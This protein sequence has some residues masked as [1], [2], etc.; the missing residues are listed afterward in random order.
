MRC[1]IGRFSSFF[2]QQA[3]SRQLYCLKKRCQSKNRHLKVLIFRIQEAW[4]TRRCHPVDV[5]S[6]SRLSTAAAPRCLS[7]ILNELR[8]PNK[9]LHIF[10]LKL[11]SIS[12]ICKTH[13]WKMIATSYVDPSRSYLSCSAWQMSKYK[14]KFGRLNL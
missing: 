3:N 8:K 10:K 2:C 6:P 7:L 11:E 4:R 9:P 13:R 14:P 12:Q 1:S 5:V